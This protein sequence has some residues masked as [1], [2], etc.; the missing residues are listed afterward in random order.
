M[1]RHNLRRESHGA[2]EISYSFP[3]SP[4]IRGYA[5][6]FNGYGESLIDYNAPITRIG[7][8]VALTDW[9]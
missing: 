9:L 5:Q 3:F 4:R 7:V 6:I 2:V 1:F 8:G